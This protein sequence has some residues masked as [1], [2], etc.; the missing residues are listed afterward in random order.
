MADF[1]DAIPA[2]EI[3]PETAAVVEVDGREIAIVHTGGQFYAMQN[4]C[5]HAAFPIGE[6]DLVGE[7]V[8]ECPGHG[9]QFNVTTGDVLQGPAL[10][11]LETYE[12]E[13]VDGMVRVA[14]E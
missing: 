11:A 4:D 2:D 7:G 12:V 1:V 14:I 10:E 3:T 9:S 6:G 13:V 8:I 5:T